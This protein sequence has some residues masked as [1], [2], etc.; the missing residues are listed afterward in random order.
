M[1]ECP[2]KTIGQKVIEH[3]LSRRLFIGGGLAL[4]AGAF[5]L[6]SKNKKK[7]DLSLFAKDTQVLLHVAYHLL[8]SSKIAPSAADL[9]IS[10]YF[11]FVLK[12]ERIMK[13]DRD[14]L[15]KGAYWLE[16]SSFEEYDK[17]FLHLN[18]AEKEE[19]LN[20]VSSYRWGEN[21]IYAS[22]TY[23]FEAMVSAPIYGSN[24]DEIGWKWLHHNPGFPQPRS[25][26]EIHY[27]I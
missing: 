16:E 13:E 3:T 21:F 23:I 7:L 18:R 12:D 19:L 1:L 24:I 20:D 17:S 22:L 15:L 2:I 10:S 8:P 25:Q 9:H 4:S 11:V 5:V 6:F 26:K 14:Y 27:D